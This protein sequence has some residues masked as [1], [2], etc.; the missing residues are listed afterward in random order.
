MLERAKTEMYWFSLLFPGTTA[1][2]HFPASDGVVDSGTAANASAAVTSTTALAGAAAADG[3]TST[4]R[5]AADAIMD[6]K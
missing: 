5:S 3:S 6:D 2:I 4:V 1:I